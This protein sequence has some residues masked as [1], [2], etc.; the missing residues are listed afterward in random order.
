MLEAF[1]SGS[2]QKVI[3]TIDYCDASSYYGLELAC[4][5]GHTELIELMLSKCT[6]NRNYGLSGACR[7]GNMDLVDRMISLGAYD[8]NQGLEGACEGG[9]RDLVDIMI[10]KG[11]SSKKKLHLDWGINHAYKGGNF[12]MVKYMQTKNWYYHNYRNPRILYYACFSGNVQ[13]VKHAISIGAHWFESG[14]YGACEGGHWELVE[15]MITHGTTEWNMGLRGACIGGHIDLVNLMISKGAN[16][17]NRALWGACRSGHFN[18]IELLVA[19]GANY[20]EYECL[21]LYFT[22][23]RQIISDII[24]PDIGS[25]VTKYLVP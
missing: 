17:W 1:R 23:K 2:I 20:D 6:G 25:V 13:L 9:H 8:W 14:L 7:A 24:G 15:L 18:I 4:F 21:V 10:S 5:Y 3:N 19:Y 11:R 12:Q 22:R 16:D